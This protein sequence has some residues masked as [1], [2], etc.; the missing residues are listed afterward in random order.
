[1]ELLE[2]GLPPGKLHWIELTFAVVLVNR[3][4]DPAQIVSILLTAGGVVLNVA[5]CEKPYSAVSKE[6]TRKILFKNLI[7]M[8]IRRYAKKGSFSKYLFMN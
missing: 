7:R 4:W 8:C 5:D 1:M 3:I 6:K 2:A